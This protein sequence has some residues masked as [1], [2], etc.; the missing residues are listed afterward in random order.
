MFKAIRVSLGV[1]RSTTLVILSSNVGVTLRGKVGSSASF[2]LGG[3]NDRDA[4]EVVETL[5]LV[6]DLGTVEGRC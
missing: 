3:W 4:E 2:S 6:H 5:I 1:L